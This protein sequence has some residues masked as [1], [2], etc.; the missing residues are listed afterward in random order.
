MYSVYH[1]GHKYL[2]LLFECAFF[3]CVCLC[4]CVCLLYVTIL[5]QTSY[6]S[7]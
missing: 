3:L 6:V 1:K 4:L 5:R 2:G 7:C